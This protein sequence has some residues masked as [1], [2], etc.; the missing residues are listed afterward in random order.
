MNRV[1]ISKFCQESYFVFSP[2][3]FQFFTFSYFVET[4]SRRQFDI[5]ISK[6]YTHQIEDTSETNWRCF[7]VEVIASN[8]A[9]SFFKTI[10]I[11]IWREEKAFLWSSRRW[12]SVGQQLFFTKKTSLSITLLWPFSNDYDR[13][14]FSAFVFSSNFHFVSSD[15]RSKVKNK[16]T[17]S[18]SN[19][20][21]QEK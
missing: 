10:Q 19:S 2:A 5:K 8:E 13:K 9:L 17:P 6:H 3:F 14:N 18:R 20:K 7:R 4:Y 11:V 21:N 1:K 15:R 16:K 12:A